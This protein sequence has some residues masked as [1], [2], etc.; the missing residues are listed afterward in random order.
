M[1]VRI[2]DEHDAPRCSSPYVRTWI[3]EGHELGWPTLDDLAYHLTTLFPPVP[4]PGWLELRMID[5]RSPTVVARRGRVTAALLDDP[6]AAAVAAVRDGAGC[7][8]AGS[9][10]PQLGLARPRLAAAARTCFDAALERCRRLGAARRPPAV[11]P[12]STT[13]L[14]RAR[15][16]CPADDGSTSGWRPDGVA[17]RARVAPSWT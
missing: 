1:L 15:G 9:T 4:T 14:R 7:A 8:T 5:A 17:R 12:R 10:P 2:D 16:R 6:D 11:L 13:P 3:D